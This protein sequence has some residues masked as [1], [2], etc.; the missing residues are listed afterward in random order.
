MQVAALR[1]RLI[2]QDTRRQVSIW[3]ADYP[4]LWLR[5]LD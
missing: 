5:F 4:L 3:M 2:E 1:I